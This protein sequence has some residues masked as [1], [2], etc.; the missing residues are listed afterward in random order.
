MHCPLLPPRQHPTAGGRIPGDPRPC[1]AA[2]R[3]VQCDA[4]AAGHPSEPC[5]EELL[6]ATGG[7]SHVAGGEH[8]RW[9][10]VCV[11]QPGRCK[12]PATPH[13]SNTCR[14][15]G[16][17]DVRWRTAG[18]APCATVYWCLLLHPCGFPSR[19]FRPGHASCRRSAFLCPELNSAFLCPELNWCRAYV[20]W[21][22]CS[23]SSSSPFGSQL[24]ARDRTTPGQPLQDSSWCT[25]TG[26][27]VNM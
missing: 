9:L 13:G 21:W 16:S 2:Q 19:L 5:A 14:R 18:C 3:P 7:G 25:A 1:A 15:P 20:P 17:G 24:G 23:S 22:R 27:H 11:A 12:L 26:R 8:L 10:G 4:R 6:L